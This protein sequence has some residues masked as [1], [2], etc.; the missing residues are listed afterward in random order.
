[1][2]VMHWNTTLEVSLFLI[3]ALLI[4]SL[5]QLFSSFLAPIPLEFIN[6]DFPLV[7]ISWNSI[8]GLPNLNPEVPS[9]ATA[10]EDFNEDD[11]E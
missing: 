7:A 10:V 4:V 5:D 2:A 8:V 6:P 9:L 3:G 1:M 11:L